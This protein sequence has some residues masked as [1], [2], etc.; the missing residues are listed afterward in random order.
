M[1]DTWGAV[2]RRWGGC[3]ARSERRCMGPNAHPAWAC[4]Y[5]PSPGYLLLRL[6]TCLPCLPMSHVLAP[7]AA[8]RGCNISYPILEC[9]PKGMMHIISKGVSGPGIRLRTV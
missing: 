2:V 7:K 1:L 9:K 5:T 8:C 6:Q 4:A 3:A